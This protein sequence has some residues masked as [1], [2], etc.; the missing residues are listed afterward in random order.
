MPLGLRP[1]STP[2][3]CG[4]RGSPS[5]PK[6]A[7][8]TARFRSDSSPN[9]FASASCLSGSS[10]SCAGTGTSTSARA[11]ASANPSIPSG[12]SS[13]IDAGSASSASTLAASSPLAATR[14]PTLGFPPWCVARVDQARRT[15]RRRSTTWRGR[16]TSLASSAR[17]RVIAQRMYPKAKA[18]K[19][20]SRPL[21]N[22]RMASSKPTDPSCTRSSTGRPSP[23]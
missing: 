23:R 1:S 8:M 19:S 9:A 15:A 10:A 12:S 13:E 3:C 4:G 20:A 14:S 6:C 7:A 2:I 22:C 5:R 16:R 21:S 11:P 17:A 18:G